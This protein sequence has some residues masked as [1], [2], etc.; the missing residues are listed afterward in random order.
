MPLTNRP[1]SPRPPAPPRCGSRIRRDPHAA[2]WGAFDVLRY[3]DQVVRRS[4]HAE[5]ARPSPIGGGILDGYRLR[6]HVRRPM[7]L[8]GWLQSG[9][10]TEHIERRESESLALFRF[11]DVPGHAIR[12]EHSWSLG[13]TVDCHPPDVRLRGI[14]A[15]YVA[16][17]FND[18]GSCLAGTS[19]RSGMKPGGLIRIAGDWWDPLHCSQLTT[20]DR[21]GTTNSLRH[22]IGT[23]SLS[24]SPSA[25]TRLVPLG[26]FL[27]RAPRARVLDLP[28]ILEIDSVDCTSGTTGRRRR[29]LRISNFTIQLDRP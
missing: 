27:G 22:V 29:R 3:G 25:L 19:I 12:L 28:E 11:P 1:V 8:R 2:H 18:G 20:L 14:P 5:D 17:V 10:S 4:G 9:A 26:K 24:Q 7:V 15:G 13:S 16:R 6:L 21:Q 23:T